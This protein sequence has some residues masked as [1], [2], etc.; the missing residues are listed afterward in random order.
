MEP[1]KH[2]EIVIGGRYEVT[3]KEG[4]HEVEVVGDYGGAYGEGFLEVRIDGAEETVPLMREN[5]ESWLSVE[6]MKD[7]RFEQGNEFS[8][9]HHGERHTIVIVDDCGNGVLDILMDGEVQSMAKEQ[10]EE[11]LSN[12]LT[13]DIYAIHTGNRDLDELRKSEDISNKKEPKDIFKDNRK[14]IKKGITREGIIGC[15]SWL[16]VLGLPVL[17]GLSIYY[18][19]RDQRLKEKAEKAAAQD[20]IRREHERI[21]AKINSKEY[22]DSVAAVRKLRQDSID[23]NTMVMIFKS[24][25][26]CHYSTIC[27]E[28]KDIKSYQFTS[29]YNAKQ[30]G[31]KICPEC[32]EREDYYWGVKDGDYIYYEDLNDEQQ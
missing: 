12:P 16:L 20:S 24:D 22:K 6:D 26:L 2:I 10:L 15:L 5:L 3:D 7:R 11:W 21:D 14:T 1:N 19:S 17:I 4:T 23:R 13:D 31:K 28:V 29:Q 9:N 18:C 27:S 30:Q 32:E 8:V 25:S